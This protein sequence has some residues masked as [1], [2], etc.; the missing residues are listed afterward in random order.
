MKNRQRIRQ[1]RVLLKA[2]P[3]KGM[4][5]LMLLLIFALAAVLSTELSYNSHRDIRRTSNLILQNEAYLYALGGEVFAK[6]TLINDFKEDKIEG[7]KVD[8]LGEVW[9]TSS[10]AY[11]V[12]EGEESDEQG[13]G[14][15]QII[16]EDLQARYNVNNVQVAATG[17]I[18]GKDQLLA[19]MLGANTTGLQTTDLVS[20]VKDWIDTDD[21][22]ASFSGGE[23]DY[24]QQLEPAYRTANTDLIHISELKSIKGMEEDAF[25]P[26]YSFVPKRFSSAPESSLNEG[27]DVEGG[28]EGEDDDEED[29][30]SFFNPNSSVITAGPPATSASTFWTGGN[31]LLTALPA[32]SK[33]NLNTAP[34]EVLK[35]FFKEDDANTLISNREQNPFNSVNSALTWLTDIKQKDYPKYQP[36][37]SVDSQYF[38]V[39]SIATLFEYRFA[40]RSVLYRTQTGE[41]KVISRDF[42]QQI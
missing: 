40:L 27:N 24:Y 5:M 4:V 32:G 2:K 12:D 29:L 41:L 26:Y 11:E 17:Q 20:A 6:Q 16:I 19:V 10:A 7:L 36:Y 13:I 15:I 39:T 38:E 3:Q 23:D 14:E 25:T 33:I 8:D 42:S 30:N 21:S 22:S 1:P 31:I 18:S 9:A 35:A 34:V 28:E 37:F